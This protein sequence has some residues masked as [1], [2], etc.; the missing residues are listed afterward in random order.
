MKHWLAAFTVPAILF[1]LP[2]YAADDAAIARGAYIFAAAGCGACHTDV[3]NHGPP[4]AGGRAIVTRFGT[5]YSPN[6]TPDLVHGIGSW[7]L[8]DF[9]RALREGRGRD[10]TFLYPVFPFDSYTGM[11]DDDVADLYAY[12]MAQPPNPRPDRPSAIRFPFGFRPLLIVWRMLFFHAGP[13]QPVTGKS[14]DWN[15]GRYLAEA[16]GHCQE[17]HTPRNFLRSLERAHGYAGNPRGPDG[18]RT[19]NITPDNDTGIGQWSLG[20]IEALLKT[21]QTPDF[22]PVG[23][24]MGEMVKGT[25]A[26]HRRRPPC[27][28]RLSQILAAAPRH[29]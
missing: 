29:P 19:P 15:R 26:A 1:V 2:A 3:K 9:R 7:S 21:G 18:L 24:G 13:L 5:F 25:R 27:H 20:D 28:R 10:G 22:D 17:C 11:S 16:V 12:L 6:I 4:L 23:S 14:A 8:G